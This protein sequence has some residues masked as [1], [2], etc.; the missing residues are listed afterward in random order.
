MPQQGIDSMPWLDNS[1]STCLTACLVSRLRASAGPWPIRPTAS[2]ADWIAP[3]VARP[4]TSPVCVQVVAKQRVEEALNTVKR[5]WL[6]QS[7]WH[8][9]QRRLTWSWKRASTRWGSMPPQIT[10][11]EPHARPPDSFRKQRQGDLIF[12]SQILSIRNDGRREGHAA[13]R[14]PSLTEG[15]AELN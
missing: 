8:G 14:A 12:F 5:Q 10:S 2:D 3:S 13:K 4:K 7:P 15:G 9:P 6:P 1:R 11:F